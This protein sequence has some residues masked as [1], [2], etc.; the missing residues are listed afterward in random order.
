M[1]STPQNY[2]LQI[3]CKYNIPENILLIPRIFQVGSPN[4]IFHLNEKLSATVDYFSI[5]NPIKYLFI[6]RLDGL[7]LKET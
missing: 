6:K 7:K 3:N 2:I 1:F 5:H 4:R